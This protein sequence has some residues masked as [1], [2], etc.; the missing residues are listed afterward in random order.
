VAVVGTGAVT[1]GVVTVAVKTG[2]VTATDTVGTIEVTGGSPPATATPASPPAARP[3]TPN[4]YEALRRSALVLFTNALLPVGF[5]SSDPSKGVI[6][7]VVV[8]ETPRRG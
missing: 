7:V 8:G 1:E 4:M 5:A 6:S 3:S 2:V